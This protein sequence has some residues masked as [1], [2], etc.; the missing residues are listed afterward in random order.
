MFW[1]NQRPNASVRSMRCM[2]NC[3]RFQFFIFPVTA[4]TTYFTSP[5]CYLVKDRQH[6]SSPTFFDCIHRNM[7]VH[8]CPRSIYYP[9]ISDLTASIEDSHYERLPF[10]IRGQPN[11]TDSRLMETETNLAHCSSL[12]SLVNNSLDY[13][14]VFHRDTLSVAAGKR[15]CDPD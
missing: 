4:S 2:S 3:C 12:Q 13:A 7:N 10:L 1:I 14:P 15:N 5:S 9:L 8:K 6:N 11:K